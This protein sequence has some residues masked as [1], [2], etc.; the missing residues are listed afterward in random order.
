MIFCSLQW[1][2]YLLITYYKTSKSSFSPQTKYKLCTPV[3]PIGCH[4]TRYA[5]QLC[6]ATAGEPRRLT[7]AAVSRP[8]AEEELDRGAFVA[9]GHGGALGQP[10]GGRRPGQAQQTRHGLV[11]HRRRQ[12]LE[13]RSERGQMSWHNVGFV[14]STAAFGHWVA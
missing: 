8:L 2:P 6:P 1:L 5:A 9:V 11:K 10:A 3:H 7:G 14:S 13:W 4:R 12:A